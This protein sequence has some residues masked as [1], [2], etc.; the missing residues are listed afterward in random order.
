VLKKQITLQQKRMLQNE[1][2]IS[3]MKY[4]L[5]EEMVEYFDLKNI[6]ENGE[7]LHLYLDEIDK[8]PEEYNDI[9]LYSN[10]F[11]EESMIKDFPLREKKVILHIRR[12]RWIDSSGQSYAKQWELTAKGT[13]YSK[14]F[15]FFLKE[16]FGYLP[17]NSP[18]S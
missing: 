15:A 6:D 12:R 11:Y 9:V 4:V 14:E 16:A 2:L 18:I 5:P 1:L 8:K 17:D 10:G 3:L 7:V 13:R